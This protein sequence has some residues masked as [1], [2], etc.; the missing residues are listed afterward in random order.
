MPYFPV[1]IS[2][3]KKYNA[4]EE[5]VI[6]GKTVKVEMSGQSASEGTITFDKGVIVD[7][8]GLVIGNNT[9]MYDEN[10]KLVKTTSIEYTDESYFE[11]TQ[12]R[13]LSYE[14]INDDIITYQGE[15]VDVIIC[16]PPYFK[17]KEDNKSNDK[18]KNLAKH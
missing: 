10:G 6:G 3:A 16:N 18:F 8:D 13:V 9:Y 17:T 12:T 2:L 7:I 14:L 1:N 11:T 15:L 5:I 4:D